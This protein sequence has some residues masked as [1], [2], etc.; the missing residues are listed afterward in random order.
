MLGYDTP[1]TKP[2]D[3]KVERNKKIAIR[4]TNGLGKSTLLKTLLGLIKPF[5]G[6]IEQGEFVSVVYFEQE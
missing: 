4:G 2:V 1:L 6:A 5:S 3:I